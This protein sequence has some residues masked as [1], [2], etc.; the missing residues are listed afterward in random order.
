MEDLKFLIFIFLSFINIDIKGS[1][2]YYPDYM[3]LKYTNSIKGIFVWI[4][5][6]QH[7]RSYYF[8]NKKYIYQRILNNLGQKMVSLFLFYS[9][10]GIYESVKKKG[11]GY[12]KS[13]PIKALILYIKFQLI[14]LIF[15]LNS[16]ILGEKIKLKKY[17]LSMIFISSIGNSNWFAFTIIIFYIYCF[18][19]F[20]VIKNNNYN[21]IG[22]VLISIICNIH[23]HL[24]YKYF[25]RKRLY[26]IDNTF[27]FLFGFYYSFLKKYIDVILMKN[28]CIYYSILTIFTSLYYYYYKKLK[29]LYRFLLINSNFS[30]IIV[31]ITMKIRINNEF[32]LFLNSHSYSIYLLQRTVMIFI[33]KKKIF[34]K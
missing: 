12:I 1:N 10:Y 3:N 28:D 23:L 29:N 9:G 6:L 18:F 16:I 27:C 13:L 24:V 32:L 15:L 7:Y 22:I 4:I 20:R 26:S 17:I 33:K 19:S 5:I 31:F 2:Q 21:F 14:L 34:R 25:Y 8:I 11:L 30:L